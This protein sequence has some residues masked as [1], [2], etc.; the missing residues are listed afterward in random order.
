MLYTLYIKI[1]LATLRI[2]HCLV[3]TDIYRPDLGNTE[4]SVSICIDGNHNFPRS[5]HFVWLYVEVFPGLI[6]P[7]FLRPGTFSQDHERGYASALFVEPACPPGCHLGSHQPHMHS[8]KSPHNKRNKHKQKRQKHSKRL[9]FKQQRAA[10]AV[11]LLC[12]YYTNASLAFT[13]WR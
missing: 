9:K 7:F 5:R 1:L 6:V 12:S 13:Q 8:W 11:D 4:A 3:Y 2:R 10:R